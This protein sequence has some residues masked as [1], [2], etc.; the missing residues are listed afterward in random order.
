M[1]IAENR[2]FDALRVG[3]SAEIARLCTEDDLYA[4][5]N[6]SGNHNPL[7]LAG[8]DGDGD[9]SPE[10][11]APALW[12]GSLIS[13]VIGNLLPGAGTLYR[14]QHFAFHDRAQ[15]GDEL[16]ARVTVLEKRSG[17]ETLLE[18]TVV[19]QRDGAT[20]LSGQAVV[21]APASK[22][23]FDDLEIPGLIVQRHRHFERLLARAEALDPIPTAVVAP[24]EANALGGALLGARHTLIAPIL[25]G[26]TSAIQAA[27]AEIDASL[28]G[29]EI[30]E[31]ETHAKAAEIAVDLVA[32]GR[33]KALMK[34]HLHTD[35][36]LR[37]CL[38][39]ERGLRTGRRLTHVFVMD[40]PGMGHPLL[41]SD[42]AINIAPDLA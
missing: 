16:L 1:K 31:A 24:E 6:V 21:D 8:I 35:A 4:F 18:T 7:H 33:A 10:A 34:G 13:A 23:I 11:I 42:A 5:A 29:I 32:E 30:V 27:A 38:R 22:M 36:L 28:E 9:G 12:V 39:R 25:I 40:V 2:P 3:E 26:R 37:A 14:S 41:V 15:A 19:R 17:R 20:I